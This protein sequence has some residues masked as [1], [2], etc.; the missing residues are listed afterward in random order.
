MPMFLNEDEVIRRNMGLAQERF[1]TMDDIKDMPEDEMAELVDGRLYY[2]AAPTARHQEIVT[3]LCWKIQGYLRENG[4]TCKVYTAP[5]AVFL[6]NDDYNYF[7][8]DITVVCDK[9]KMKRDGCHGAPDFVSEIVSESSRSLDYLT[10]LIK[11]KAAGVREYWIIDPLRQIITAYD[12]MMDE[13][14]QFTFADSVRM[15]VFKDYSID[16][17]ELD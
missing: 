5:Y 1:Y 4:G 11:Y 8:P 13:V 12:F 2:M 7:M 6:S 17:K 10:K 14:G 9:D 3:F 15:C 16:F